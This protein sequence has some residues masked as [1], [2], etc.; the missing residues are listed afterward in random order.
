MSV[1]LRE[2]LTGQ[3]LPTLDSPFVN[4]SNIFLG[5]IGIANTIRKSCLDPI[6]KKLPGDGTPLIP[7]RGL[8]RPHRDY[9][10]FHLAVRTRFRSAIG[11][12]FR[13]LLCLTFERNA[14]RFCIREGLSLT[15]RAS[16]IQQ[17][18]RGVSQLPVS[19]PRGN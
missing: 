10:M 17:E 4:M 3:H 1:L 2:N 5:R 13:G 9:E 14:D 7:V 11:P 12:V 19:T 15:G 16:D 18:K 6:W 8:A